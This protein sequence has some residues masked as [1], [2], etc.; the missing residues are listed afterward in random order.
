MRKRRGAVNPKIFSAASP[1]MVRQ[2]QR[3][4]RQR[5]VA[6]SMRSILNVLNSN[7]SLDQILTEIVTQ[8][9]SLLNADAA[10]IYRLQANGMLTIQSS[11]G[12]GEDY[13][14]LGSIPLGVLATGRAAVELRPVNIQ[15]ISVLRHDPDSPYTHLGWVI[16]HLNTHYRAILS[17]PLII[18]IETYGTLTL[19]FSR[20]YS[21]PA[22]EAD[23]AVSFSNQAALAIENATLRARSEQSAVAAERNRL[24]RELH[25]SVSQMLFSAN[26]IADVLP[27]IWEKDPTS[28]REGL[29]KLRQLTHGAQAEMRTL[30]LELRPNA[31]EETPLDYLLRQL[32]EATTGRF[33]I[34]VD[35]QI[36]GPLVLTSE[37]RLVFY[38]IAQEALNNI[39]KHAGAQHI[40]LQVSGSPTPAGEQTRQVALTITDDGCG[41]D[42]QGVTA[43][44]LGLGIMKERAQ[45]IGAE[46]TIG[47]DVDCGTKVTVTWTMVEDKA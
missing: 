1:E 7:R 8:A 40:G 32:A 27:S 18:R 38:R 20:P 41:F 13:V 44:H 36:Q 29:E 4:D 12:L 5:Q 34:P 26:L 2:L 35:L 28:G 19:Y 37:V 17:V 30:L 21:I 39:G 10:A 9:R 3:L 42:Q 31:L 25:D 46:I 43:D 45:S 16:E 11:I 47:P 23:L 14:A 6:E 24:A 33:Q 22:E 15:D